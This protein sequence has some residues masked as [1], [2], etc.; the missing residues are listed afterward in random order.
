LSQLQHDLG[1]IVQVGEGILVDQMGQPVYYEMLL[2]QDEYSYIVRNGLYAANTQL[3]FAQQHGIKLPTGITADGPT[4]AIEIKAAW[5]VMSAAELAEQPPRFHTR[6]A[7]IHDG[8]EVTVGLVGLHIYQRLGGFH[9]GV[10]A[11]FSHVDNSPL[12]GQTPVP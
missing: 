5:K 8:T 10:W 3:P 1:E 12:V 9:Q 4:G 11:T 6:P 2:N 7:V